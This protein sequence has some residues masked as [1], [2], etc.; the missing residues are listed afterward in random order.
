M[1][2]VAPIETTKTGSGATKIVSSKRIVPKF[3]AYQSDGFLTSDRRYDTAVWL[4]VQ[5][6]NDTI[7]KRDNVG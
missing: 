4:R 5:A 6:L 1:A 2:A 3:V 7:V